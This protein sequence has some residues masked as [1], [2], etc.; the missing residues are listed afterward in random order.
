[1]PRGRRVSCPACP[2]VWDALQ[3]R[4]CGRCG[5]RLSGPVRAGSVRYRRA[6]R[7]ERDGAGGRAVAITSG[8]LALVV[9]LVGAAAVLPEPAMTGDGEVALPTPGELPA[10]GSPDQPL[11]AGPTTP[12]VP[13][14]QPDGCALWEAHTEPGQVTITPQ[15]T[16]YHLRPTELT[17]IDAADGRVG[18][19]RSLLARDGEDATGHPAVFPVDDDLLLVAFGRR[20]EVEFRWTGDGKLLW[21]TQLDASF[22]SSVRLVDGVVVIAGGQ[23]NRMRAGGPPASAFV[24][25]IDRQTRQV[26]WRRDVDTVI[27]E[28]GVSTIVRDRDGRLTALDP[29]TGG[30]RWS[31]S[32]D[33]AASILPGERLVVAADPRSIDVIDRGTGERSHTIDRPAGADGRIERHEDLLT[34]RAR[35]GI[36]PS[37][38]S[39]TDVLVVDLSRPEAPLQ[40]FPG[41]GGVVA[42]DDGLVIVTQQGAALDLHLLDGE[43]REVWTRAVELADP[44]CCWRL[45]PSA[46]ADALLVVPPRV[47]RE[48]IRVLSTVDGT[49]RSSFR[50]SAPLRAAPDLRWIGPVAMRFDG[51]N[52]VLAGPGGEVRVPGHAAVVSPREPLLLVTSEG[53]LAIDERRVTATD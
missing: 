26:R 50:L 39:R 8:L 44:A 27:G 31:R 9:V 4:F 49:T 45:E 23:T 2:A 43:G 10:P 41:A 24:T 17:R 20:G 37:S 25:G 36:D 16:I 51:R 28:V 11:A 22:I 12:T 14:C 15:G 13:G 32:V 38:R 3:A 18:W 48:P 47:D 40:R 5:A 42:A 7:A 46:I 30:Q 29:A 34:L 53:L 35:T 6:H 1:M 33:R 19:R 52:T 21:Q